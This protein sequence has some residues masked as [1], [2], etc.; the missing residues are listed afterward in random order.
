M[1]KF[2]KLRHVALCQRE[3]VMTRGV[4]KVGEQHAV[5]GRN[6]ALSQL[7]DLGLKAV[8]RVI[9]GHDKA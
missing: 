7:I 2:E 1:P 9:R 4:V 5:I 3:K 6:N 8:E